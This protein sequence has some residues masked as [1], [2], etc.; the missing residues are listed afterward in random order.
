MSQH[1]PYNYLDFE[2]DSRIFKNQRFIGINKHVGSP[3]TYN[4]NNGTQRGLPVIITFDYLMLYY[5][6]QQRFF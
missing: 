5:I 1:G 4:G 2:Q 3:K 6:D